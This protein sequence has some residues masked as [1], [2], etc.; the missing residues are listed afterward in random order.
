MGGGG[1]SLSLSFSFGP[2]PGKLGSDIL[3]QGL[4]QR[5][6]PR[7]CR[8]GAGPPCAPPAA[9]PP[10]TALPKA[11]GSHIPGFVP[12]QASLPCMHPMGGRGRSHWGQVGVALALKAR[13]QL[14][15]GRHQL[16]MRPGERL[17]LQCGSSSSSGVCVCVSVMVVVR[18]GSGGDGGVCMG[19]WVGGV[20][21][22]WWG[23]QR[24][25]GSCREEVE[26]CRHSGQAQAAAQGPPCLGALAPLVGGEQPWHV[27]R[28]IPPAGGAGARNQHLGR[29]RH[30]TQLGEVARCARVH[31]RHAAAHAC[32]PHAQPRRPPLHH[33]AVGV[34][35]GVQPALGVAEQLEV[36]DMGR[37]QRG[38]RLAAAGRGR[39][40]GRPG[41]RQWEG[42]DGLSACREGLAS[43]PSRS[44]R[45]RPPG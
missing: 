15:V 22:W 39:E 9:V 32:H 43:W 14:A 7:A 24:G 30:W 28:G 27:Q 5:A 35:A 38:A 33:A 4:R 40:K 34:G 37:V 31:R 41:R 6:L 10:P 12:G 44:V 18:V 29:G 21:G 8:T 45:R 11:G 2:H 1:G 19:V 25:P 36:E 20:V 26:G 16:S 13:R 3:N 23:P 42:W 17:P